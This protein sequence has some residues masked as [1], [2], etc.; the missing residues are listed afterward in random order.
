MKHLNK[1]AS[2]FCAAAL[3]MLALTSCEGGELYKVNA[4]DWVAAKVD[5]I[6]EANKPEELVGMMDD[7][8]TVG[9]TD[10]S[11][12]FWSAFSKYYVI[13]DGTKWNAEVNVYPNPDN[14]YY[15][16][17]A[18]IVTNDADRGATN[19]SEYGAYRYDATGDSIK[20]NSQWG[21]LW[22][23][24]TTS[25]LGLSPDADS[26]DPNAQKLAG[27][28]T[29]TV[30]R[31]K[32]GEFIIRMDNGSVVK[33]YN[34][35]YELG[36]GED[37]RCFLVVD[38]SYLQFLTTNIEPIGGCTSKEDKQPVSMVLNNVPSEIQQ[39]IE[40]EE[41]MK[42]V[43]A[44][45]T[46]EQDVV[47]EIEAGDLVF[48][49]I[50]DIADPGKK[51]LVVMYAKTTN[52]A[53]AVKP[54]MASAEFEVVPS[55]DKMTSLVV[56]TAPKR[57]NYYY[58]N[59]AA[60]SDVKDRTFV[61]DRE[62]LEL[63]A[64]Y[65]GGYTSSYNLDSLEYGTV[66]AQAGTQAVTL[67][68][69]N[70]KTV[71][72]NVTV[73]ESALKLH[74]MAEKDLGTEDCATG[75]WSVFTNDVKVPAGETYQVD[76]TN[77]GNTINNWSNF[78]VILRNSKLAESAVVRADYFGW[79]AGYDG[80]PDLRVGDVS[81]L[82]PAEPADENAAWWSKW[83]ESMNGAKVSLYITNLNNGTAD[84]QAVMKGS[85]GTTYKLY[86]LNIKAVEPDDMNFSFTVDG[87]YLVF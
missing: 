45:V 86:Y 59:S 35:P 33:T 54:I 10:Y 32:E 39:G 80:N 82:P 38:G 75:W 50:P 30:D 74:K 61:F 53:A 15:K 72:V 18:L 19:Y 37:I 46:Y 87:S 34:Q 17:V 29:L 3:G 12:G 14:V 63:T 4:P 13:P 20:W 71:T 6:A 51:T 41:A 36:S 85:D 31:S 77:Y 2:A 25:T 48:N 5:S 66:K 1:I 7:Y 28:M 56:K 69:K 58:Y 9:A 21:K 84:V 26:K 11:N 43:T 22:F 55:A 24:Y 8:Y 44:T 47:A 62:G 70:G 40:L 57:T 73:S 79:G 16:N 76:F 60:V 81:I 23:K 68:A 52:G 64:T 65:E 42:G 49:S 27:K 78:V 83:R 67:K